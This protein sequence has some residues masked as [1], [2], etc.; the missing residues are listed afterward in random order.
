NGMVGDD[1]TPGELIEFN[2]PDGGRYAGVLKEVS[3]TS[4]L[5]DFNHP[6]AGQALTFEVKI[7]GIL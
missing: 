6:L 4:A 5:F 7:I 3:E 2:A 1:F